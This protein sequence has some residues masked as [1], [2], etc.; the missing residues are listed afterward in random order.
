LLPVEATELRTT[1]GV[2]TEKHWHKHELLVQLAALQ[3]NRKRVVSN[4]RH[5]PRLPVR[6][7]AEEVQG[8]VPEAECYKNALKEARCL[9]LFDLERKRWLADAEHILACLE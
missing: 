7:R 9:P 8:V 4:K 3:R 1:I 5:E 2:V 6:A